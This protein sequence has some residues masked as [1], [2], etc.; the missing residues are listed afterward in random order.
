MDRVLLIVVVHA[1]AALLA[2]VAWRAVDARRERAVWMRLCASGADDALCFDPDMVADLPDPARRYFLATIARGT[3]LR[4]AVE[5]E[6]ESE[7]GLGTK[8]R[9]SYQ[10]MRA[11]QILGRDGFVWRVSAGDGLLRMSGSDGFHKGRSWTRIRLLGLL[12]VVRAVGPDH[13]RSA[14]GRLV[15]ESA[16]WNPAVLLPGQEVA[17]E[18]VLE[19][20]ARAIVRRAGFTQSVE[21]TVGEDGLPLRVVIPRWTN[22][23]PERAWRLQPFGG[24][25]WDYRTFDGLTLPT[26]VEGG[27]LFGTAD[28][29]PFYRARVTAVRPSRGGAAVEATR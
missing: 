3:P 11:R 22:A 13:A 5:I 28:Y 2:L 17:W 25:L 14:F 24:E 23:N 26:R 1:L 4:L 8:A 19:D 20:T 7:I 29:F 16:F 21:V 12:P 18:A 27:N 9:P 15:A 6:T 10:R